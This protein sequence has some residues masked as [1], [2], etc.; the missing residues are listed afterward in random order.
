MSK[1]QIIE[2]LEDCKDYFEDKADADHK[3]GKFV[4]NKEM[5]LSAQ[6][7]LVIIQLN[8]STK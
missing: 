7:T 3:Q 2:V 8:K 6:L 5:T 4:P 1:E